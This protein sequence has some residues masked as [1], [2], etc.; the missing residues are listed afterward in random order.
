MLLA[1]N[2]KDEPPL[3]GNSSNWPSGQALITS[4]QVSPLNRTAATP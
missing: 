1:S 4:A 2:L 3:R